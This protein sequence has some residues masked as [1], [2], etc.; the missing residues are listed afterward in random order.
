MTRVLARSLLAVA[1]AIAISIAAAPFLAALLSLRGDV[2]LIPDTA[3]RSAFVVSLEIG[4]V[5]TVVATT[6]GTSFA[7]LVDGRRVALRRLWLALAPGPLVVPP[8]LVAA[9][10]I[11]LF[12][13]AGRLSGPLGALLGFPPHE[14]GE[15]RVGVL[16]ALGF[17]YTAPSAGIVLGA[18]AFPLVALAV[19]SAERRIDPRLL[20]V[21]RL[22]RGRAG[23]WRI[24]AAL[25]AP[26][27]AGGALLAFAF[28][29]ADF[30]APLVLRVRTL[31]EEVYS[32][33]SIEGEHDAGSAV[34]A[35][36]PLL[37]AI[38][39][40]AGL[41][42]FFIARARVAVDPSGE[43]RRFAPRPASRRACALS[44]LV[45]LAALAPG[46][47]FPVASMT[48]QATTGPIAAPG[49]PFAPPST[50]SPGAIGGTERG[51]RAAARRAWAVAGKDARSSLAIAATSAC[52]AVAIG[53]LA[54]R[55]ARSRRATALGTVIAAIPLAVPAPLA[56]AGLIALLDRPLT[57]RVYDSPAVLVIAHLA[58]FLPIAWLLA[59]GALARIDPSL[60]ESAAL[61]GAGPLRRAAR[62]VLP[63]AAPGLVAAWLA[64]YVLSC[65]EYGAS[66]L[67]TPPGWPVL[68][69]T[70][71]N[72]VHYGQNA[73]I[74]AVGL[75]LLA[76]VL[77]PL[78]LAGSVALVKTR[79][80][81][82]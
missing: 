52:A 24:H 67:V 26:S 72:S 42:A 22:A 70:V 23:A 4:V 6:L 12:G 77:A 30:A 74:A 38:L 40:A 63:L 51:A 15:A 32:R 75:L 61:A 71:A 14:P 47:I 55:A 39:I 76:I 8:Y 9:S 21:A 56:G 3:M 49:D 5:A 79:E 37:A 2:R 62:V 80:V 58:R 29:L 44:I 81:T 45:A 82:T 7:L 68:A 57:A 59:H 66:V 20:E 46:L 69:N 34:A 48:V 28:A 1:A 35:G 50:D 41:A 78:A 54:A 31:N 36:L 10:W 25:L 19:A 16:K 13:P 18:C 33:A 60:E 53:G 27:I 11:D 73:E 64:V 43:A 17:V 65:I